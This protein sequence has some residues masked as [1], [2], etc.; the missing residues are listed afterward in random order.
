ML[1]RR[2]LLSGLVVAG[3]GV[4]L[5]G[6]VAFGSGGTEALLLNCIDYRLTRKTA[7]FMANHRLAEKY[8]N[9]EI[10]GAALG[11]NNDKYPDWGRTF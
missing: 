10:A 3:G 9:T 4:A 8:D 2:R 1:G 11:A 5:S 7:R 6:G